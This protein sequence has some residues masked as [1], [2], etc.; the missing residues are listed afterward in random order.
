MRGFRVQPIGLIRSEIKNRKDAPRFY[1]EGAPNATL[2]VVWKFRAG[3][4]RIKVGDE[5]IV[6]TWLH[7]AHRN[8]LRVHPRGD[9]SRPLTGVFLTRSPDRPNPIGLHR[10]RVLEVKRNR[11]LIGPIEAID[12]T[13]VVDIKSVVEESND[14]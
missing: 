14:F 10:V 1:T 5:V 6:I 13:P 2:E 3:L 11:L 7:R 9:T 8:I 4:D 12:G